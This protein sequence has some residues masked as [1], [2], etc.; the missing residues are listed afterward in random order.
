MAIPW[1][2]G[3]NKDKNMK[4]TVRQ[5]A[6]IYGLILGDGYIQK[7]G[8]KNARLRLEH[9]IKQ[10]KYIE[11][12]YQELRNIFSNKPKRVERIHPLSR[13]KY[14]YLRLQSH[15]SPFF[16]R[17]YKIFYTDGKKH[18]P[19]DIHTII[20]HPLTLAVWYMD[21]G[22][23][24]KRDK[25][26]HIYLPL[27]NKENMQKLL[28]A[29]HN[30]HKLSPKYYCRPDKK[31]CQLNFTGEQLKTLVRIVKPYIL[32]EFNYKIPLDPVTTEDE[33]R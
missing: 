22:Y 6:I 25:S 29:L 31:G 19:E 18:I 9:S 4:L 20:K 13:K 16:G 28:K 24:Y 7:T 32:P 23:Y 5:K 15:S 27:L 11:W 10:K 3:G 30:E 17:L 2:V 1:E 26:A 14:I 33:N 21:D 8:Q 12:K